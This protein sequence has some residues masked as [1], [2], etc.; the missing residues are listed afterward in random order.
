MIRFA[1]VY[2]T[3]DMDRTLAFL[4]VLGLAPEAKHRNGGW[5]EMAAPHAL[6]QLHGSPSAMGTPPGVATLSFES[7]E[8]PDEVA[9]RLINAGFADAAVLDE[10]YGRIVQLTGPDGQQV[11]LNFSDRSLYT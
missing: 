8:D 3:A 1:P 4:A 2:F 5:V 9:A 6:L 11:Q 10:N 7:D